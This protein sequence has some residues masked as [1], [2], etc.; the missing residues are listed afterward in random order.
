MWGG[1]QDYIYNP[2]TATAINAAFSNLNVNNAADPFAQ[3]ILAYTYYQPY[4]TYL[5][6]SEFTYGKPVVNPP[7]LKPFTDVPGA[8]SSTVAIANLTTLV[9]LN[10]AGNPDGLR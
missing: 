2:A 5:I 8:I 4:Y 1:S 6:S 7:I 3:A 10:A 9:A